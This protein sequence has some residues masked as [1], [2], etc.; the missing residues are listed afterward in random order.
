MSAQLSRSVGEPR[1]LKRILSRAELAAGVR[2]YA[3]SQITERGIDMFADLDTYLPHTRIATVFDVGA[4]VGQSARR[5]AEEFPAAII[6]S[7]EP[8][9]GTF[10]QLASSVP[11]RVRCHQIAL[12]ATADVG[13]MVKQGKTEMFYLLGDRPAPPSAAL[14]QVSIDTLDNFCER[15][16]IQRIDLLKIDTEGSDMAVLQGAERLLRE[17][18][19]GIIQV[20]ASMNSGNRHHV[21]FGA[22]M[23]HL[24]ANGYRLFGIYEQWPEWPTGEPHMRRSNPVFIS[25][26][27]IA[28]NRRQPSPLRQVD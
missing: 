20:E 22:F 7:F 21:S 18:R 1:M 24:E 10:A 11:G 27:V 5:Y 26:Q 17:Q 14:E 25:E 19:V 8:V 4:N 16:D 6:H 2:V 12:G 3:A 28:A 9:A 23:T 15:H 13:S